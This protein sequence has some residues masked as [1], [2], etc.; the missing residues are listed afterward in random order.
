MRDEPNVRLRCRNARSSDTTKGVSSSRQQAGGGWNA[1]FWCNHDQPRVVS[2]FGDDGEHRV[3][4]AKMLATALHFLQGTPY[5]Y[6]GEELG[7]TN[8]GFN[9]IEQY[10][11]VETLNIFRLKRDAGESEAAS[12]AAIMQKSRDNG[13]TPMQWSTEVNAGFSSGEPWIGIPANAAQ[14]N[15]ESQRD[16]PDS[17]LHHYRALIALRRHEPLIQAGVYRQLLQDHLQVWAYLREGHGERLLVVNNFYGKPCEIQLPQGVINAS[18]EQRLLISNYPDCP[19][20]T[21]TVVLRPYESFVL[22]LTD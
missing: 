22:H 11:D 18:S 5:V 15:V 8:P 7:M 9:K 1:L 17:V 19:L 21:A 12:M 14:I 10:R 3:V 16:D 13:R 4:S 2:R 6:Q 20:R